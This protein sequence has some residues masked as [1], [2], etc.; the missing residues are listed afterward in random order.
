MNKD[1]LKETAAS[2]QRTEYRSPYSAL[3]DEI[4]RERV[5]RARR[6]S[7]EEKFLAGEDLFEYACSITLAG[8]QNQNPE[9]TTEECQRELSR[10]LALREHMERM[11]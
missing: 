3:V 5:V 10:R 4:Y 6:T 2:N 9:F 1:A 8:I 7:P 11:K